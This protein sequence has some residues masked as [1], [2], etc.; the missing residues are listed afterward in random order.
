MIGAIRGIRLAPEV[1]L[2]LVGAVLEAKKAKYAVTKACEVLM[3]DSRRF[4]RWIAGKDLDNL[5]AE[6]LV[7]EPPVAKVIPNKITEQERQQIID[8]ATDPDNSHLKHRKLT[9]HLSRSDKAFVSESTT[10]RV[11][12]SVQLVCA[13]I[14][15]RRP[16]A[17]KPEK[18]TTAP[19][20]IW[21]WDI[22]WLKV[23]GAF[24]YLIAI[25]DLYSRKIVGY[26]VRS[27]ATSDDVKDVFDKA[28]ANEG[29]LGMDQPMP[30]SLSDRGSQQKSKSIR[31]FFSDLGIV[32]MFARPRTPA[33]NAEIES[34]FST[35]KGERLYRAEYSSPIEMI[36]DVD[37]F[38]PYY[39][40]ERLHQGIGFVTP[41]EKHDGRWVA[42]VEARRQGMQRAQLQRQQV[43][44]GCSEDSDA[45]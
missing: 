40:E 15:A 36:E 5:V 41:A 14:S 37:V 13:F 19:N 17:Q 4:H 10:L 11:L 20:Q 8:A 25:I 34:F 32:Q 42:I 33:D 12:Q 27:Q 1:K 30:T 38:V 22:S 6:D 31:R 2:A 21:G 35:V 39:N 43:N 3:L 9:H 23:N 29:L 45:A 44:R 16:K 24:W 18:I 26:T 7:D 28:L